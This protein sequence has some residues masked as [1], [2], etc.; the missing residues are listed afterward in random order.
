MKK[1]IQDALI[2]ATIS[3]A[4]KAKLII[5]SLDGITGYH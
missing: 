5:T 2:N 1:I 4:K 3:I